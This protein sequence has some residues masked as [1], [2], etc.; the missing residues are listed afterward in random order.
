MSETYFEFG[1]AAEQW[2]RAQMFFDAKEYQTS[3][4]I[5]RGLVAEAPEQ[6]AQRLLLARSY[7]H[8]AQLGRA[9]A[10]LRAIVELNPVE[11]Y[12]RLMLGRTLERQGRAAE[13][14]P[15]LRMAAAMSGE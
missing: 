6:I 3:A 1:T 4:R 12:A 13:A 15:H 2:D 7:Y 8:S 10:E 5:L 9:E 14:A 11:H